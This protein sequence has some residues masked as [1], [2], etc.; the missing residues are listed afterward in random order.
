MLGVTDT[1]VRRYTKDYHEHLSEFTQRKRRQFTDQDITV[2]KAA[3][4]FAGEGN[5]K[6]EI[7]RLLFDANL[8]QDTGQA[9]ESFG[10]VIASLTTL[11]KQTEEQATQ[12][13]ALHAQVNATQDRQNAS[14]NRHRTWL[15][16]L[17]LAVGILFVLVLVLVVILVSRP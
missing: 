8:S 9:L 16:M 4:R 7:N 17:S 15:L 1:S 10:E 12:F 14:E 13:T 6:A 5:T 2:L 11:R 3:Q